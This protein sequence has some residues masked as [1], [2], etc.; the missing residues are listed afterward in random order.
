[1]QRPVQGAVHGVHAVRT[2]DY[3][4]RRFR[5]RYA[6]RYVNS[7]DDQYTLLH[8]NFSG[9]IRGQLSIA[10]IDMARFQRTSEGTHHSTCGCGDHIVN[11][12]GVRLFQLCWVNFVV[13]RNGPVDAEG[14]WLWLAGQVRNSE[15]SLLS[16]D[17]RLRDINNIT[18]GF[19]LSTRKNQFYSLDRL[20]VLDGLWRSLEVQ[21]N[22][23]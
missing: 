14:H 6:H 15:G 3:L 17:P 7:A 18:H 10:G 5:H 19:L 4:S 2:L 20:L 1:V 16:F 13:L 11:G 23:L 21:G 8:F 12:R 22:N 9:Y